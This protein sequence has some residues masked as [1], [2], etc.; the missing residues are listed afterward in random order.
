MK[1]DEDELNPYRPR[2]IPLSDGGRLVYDVEPHGGWVAIQPS[3]KELPLNDR[4]ASWVEAALRAGRSLRNLDPTRDPDADPLPLP[5]VSEDASHEAW[6]TGKQNPP[7]LGNITR[8]QSRYIWRAANAPAP[9]PELKVVPGEII[10]NDAHIFGG[11][12]SA[13]A[14]VIDLKSKYA[15]F[16]SD[17]IDWD[18]VP[19]VDLVA[20]EE[21]L[22]VDEK[23]KGMPTHLR[24]MGYRG[25]KIFQADV[26]RYTLRVTLLKDSRP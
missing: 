18:G 21:T 2:E 17:E 22:K 3:G 25:W 13:V 14:L 9:D 11:N 26:S 8:R 4:Q 10:V 15:R 6:F 12:G 23:R 1:K 20:D 7:F 24:L 19:C 16:L 5:E